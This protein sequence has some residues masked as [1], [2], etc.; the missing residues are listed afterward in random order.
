VLKF[1]VLQS[2]SNEIRV[3]EIKSILII[4][5]SGYA[6]KIGALFSRAGF[7]VTLTEEKPGEDSSAPGLIIE[8]IPGDSEKKKQALLRFAPADA[9]LATTIPGGVTLVASGTGHQAKTIGLHFIF[10]PFEEKCLVEIVNGLDTSA[11][12]WE[13]CRR[14]IEKAG[15]VPVSVEDVSGLIV[16]RVMASVINEAAFLYET[17]LASLEDINRIPKLCLN[18]PMGPFE[19]ADYIGIDNIVATLEAACR[20]GTQYLPCRLLRQMAAAG[21]LGK[22]TGRGFYDYTEKT[23]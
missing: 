14:L 16:D 22:K 1:K 12:T 4:G 10:N 20:D 6:G 11:E 17:K 8:A 18:W 15:A 5:T 7:E 3:S 13:T 21:K 2:V 23:Q 9:I 19:F